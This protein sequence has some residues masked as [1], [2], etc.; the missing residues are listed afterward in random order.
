MSG[1]ESHV[2]GGNLTA[3][4][5][6]EERIVPLGNLLVDA[7]GLP[8]DVIFGFLF[9]HFK[10]MDSSIAQSGKMDSGGHGH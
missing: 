3:I 1:K 2:T 8:I 7:V 4:D 5:L 10:S 6:A 9:K